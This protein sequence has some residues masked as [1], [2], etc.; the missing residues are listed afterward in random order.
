MRPVVEWGPGPVGMIM[1]QRR[2]RST[3]TL[4]SLEEKGYQTV[5]TFNASTESQSSRSPAYRM[6]A[7]DGSFY[8]GHRLPS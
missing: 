6:L 2:D 7:T 5:P 1:K 3:S 8:I 4:A